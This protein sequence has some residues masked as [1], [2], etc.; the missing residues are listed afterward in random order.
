[1]DGEIYQTLAQKQRDIS[2]RT[3]TA[4]GR[5]GRREAEPF[6]RDGSTATILLL[7]GDKLFA[8]NCGDSE[9]ILVKRDGSFQPITKNHDTLD[10]G[11]FERI[12]QLGGF[13]RK[14]MLRIPKK[15]PWCCTLEDVVVGKPRVYPG[16]LL[17]TR[18]FGDFSAKMVTLGGTPGVILPDCDEVLEMTIQEDWAEV[19]I[20]SDGVWDAVPT[21]EMAQ[22]LAQLEGNDAARAPAARSPV[23]ND[24]GVLETAAPGGA[25]ETVPQDSLRLRQAQLQSTCARLILACVRHRYWE[26]NQAAADNASAV[27]LRFH[28]LPQSSE[29]FLERSPERIPEQLPE[30]IPE[31]I[32]ERSSERSP[33]GLSE[34]LPKRGE[35]LEEQTV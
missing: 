30:R 16:G 34:G 14:Q 28:P 19:V 6:P 2:A 29:G 26:S 13:Y 9:G 31:Q 1:M 33:E 18:A 12:R 4:N 15:W 25:D 22:V 35:S 7:V 23:V 5:E 20:A 3:T 32:P 21:A 10:Q 24:P 17:V 27:I 11:E 8:A